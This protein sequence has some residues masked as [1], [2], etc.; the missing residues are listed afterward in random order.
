VTDSDTDDFVS[1]WHNPTRALNSVFDMLATALGM[2]NIANLPSLA[3]D[4]L[5]LDLP[6]CSAIYFLR[7]PDRSATLRGKNPNPKRR[8]RRNGLFYIGKAVNLRMRWHTY[9]WI[10]PDGSR[11]YPQIHQHI[12][13][14]IALKDIRLHWWECER[15]HL[16]VAES[17]LL[18]I[19]QPPWNS[20]IY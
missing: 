4:S 9:E 6:Q 10:H 18:Q 19:Y 13:A 8:R 3:V 5:Y 15:R 11:S 16:Y 20:Q 14:A 1:D 17:V 7:S 12:E 2:I